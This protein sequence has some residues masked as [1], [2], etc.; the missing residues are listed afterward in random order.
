MAGLRP[1]L[2]RWPAGGAPRLISV[3]GRC[4][5]AGDMMVMGCLQVGV[6]LLNLGW[7]P[8]QR[9]SRVGRQQGFG[10]QPQVIS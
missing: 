6:R 2:V 1:G 7:L 8:G 4:G 9:W 5:A 3:H 10:S